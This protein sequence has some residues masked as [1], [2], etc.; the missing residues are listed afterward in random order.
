[1]EFAIAGLRTSGKSCLFQA[2][3]GATG[4]VG[5]QGTQK[6]T[7][8]VP[9]ARV[10]ALTKLSNSKKT[11]Y[12]TIQLCDSPGLSPDPSGAQYNDRILGSLRDADGLLLVVRVFRS[13]V[14]PHPLGEVDP[15][16]D[17]KKLLDDLRVSDL[18]IVE[19]RLEKLETWI[20]RE[21]K[22]ER[23]RHEIERDIL[24]LVRRAAEEGVTLDLSGRS[25]SDL[26]TVRGYGLFTLKPILVVANVGDLASEDEQRRVQEL[27]EWGKPQGTPVVTIN[28]ALEGEVEEF[29]EEERAL[30]YEEMGLEGP[31]LISLLQA[32][33]TTMDLIS[34]LT[35]GEDESRAWP[36]P[37]G[38]T[39][40]RAAGAIHTDLM[41]GFIRAEVILYEDLIRL[42]GEAQAKK[43]GLMR[44]E[45]KDYLVQD[46]D[47]ILV[48]FSR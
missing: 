12:A 4:V 31:G 21:P 44:S 7:L 24:V 17:V 3:T 27:V 9:D 37:R 41:K 11:T 40:Q 19:K 38:I 33:Y 1:M 8:V 13:M 26:S 34:F 35:T 25:E 39:A 47:V 14:V 15:V 28:A 32:T 36:V 30:Y 2:L 23:E 18:G 6:G 22:P 46:G 20:P 16:R 42:G 45:G 48:H 5:G 29:P 10:D 43:A